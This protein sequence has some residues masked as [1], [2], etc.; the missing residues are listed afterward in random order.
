MMVM[1]TARDL[2]DFISDQMRADWEANRD[3][4]MAKWNGE[5]TEQ[6]LW[7][8]ERHLPWLFFSPRPGSR[9]WGAEI[10]DPPAKK[11]RR[12]GKRPLR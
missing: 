4:L 6:E 8:G 5:K 7:P 1:G 12:R 2:C 11:N 3:K 9:P 10:F